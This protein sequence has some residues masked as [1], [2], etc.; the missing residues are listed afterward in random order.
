MT[1]TTHAPAEQASAV[2]E[3]DLTPADLLSRAEAI[4]A[5]LV[6]RQAETEQRTFYAPDTHEAFAAAGLYRIL[7]P[8]RFGGY[9]F[10]VDT[11]MRVVMTLTR[12]CSS[13]GWMYCLGAAHPQAVATLFDERVQAEVFADGDFICPATVAPSGTAERTPDGDWLID[14]TWNYCS[15][16][17]YATHFVGHTLVFPE[18]ADEPH[19]MLFIA[20]RDQFRRLDDWGDQLGLKGSGSHSITLENGRVPDHCTLP[21]HLSQTAVGQDLPGAS[22]HANPMYSGGVLTFMVLE[23]AALAVGMALGALD[24]YEELLR[25]RHTIF[26]PIVPRVADPDFQF[27]YGE[28]SG[29]IA[30][31]EAAFLNA[32][33]QWHDA[34]EEGFTQERELRVV[35][36]C[37]EVVKLSWRAVQG[38]LYPT[39][40]S[41]AV[42]HGTRMERVWRDLSMQQSHAGI[43]V[44]LNSIANREFTKA[45]FGVAD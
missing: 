4:A 20:P 27:H 17:P 42:R 28:A 44:F 25:S 23:D 39:A 34:A 26:P 2:P 33:Q 35:T 37:R 1:V 38:H 32:I 9:E 29:L 24:A 11:F 40:G 19:P 6:K 41:S 5:T 18:D 22:L 14:G 31:A 8:R 7:V 15:G 12:A 10:G 36:I 16:S 3:P 45:R 43:S 30:T 13:T 21:G